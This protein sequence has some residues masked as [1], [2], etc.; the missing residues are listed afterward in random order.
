VKPPIRNRGSKPL[1][2]LIEV[3]CKEYTVP[4]GGEAIVTLDDSRAHSIDVHA[5]DFIT[6]WNE[7]KE[8]ADVEIASPEA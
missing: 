2:L 1:P 3:R 4:I 6:V 5:E 8:Q 7:G